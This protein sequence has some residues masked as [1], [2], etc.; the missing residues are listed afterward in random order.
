MYNEKALPFRSAKKNKMSSMWLTV[1]ALV[2]LTVPLTVVSQTTDLGPPITNYDKDLTVSGYNPLDMSSVIDC[3]TV[4][5]SVDTDHNG[6]IVFGG[7][8]DREPVN[9][10]CL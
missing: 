5:N 3:H 2:V 7:M 6:L 1:M 8:V 10:T 4:I 9:G